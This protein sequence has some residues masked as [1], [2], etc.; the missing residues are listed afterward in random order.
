ML[1]TILDFYD[2]KG[3]FSKTFEWISELLLNVYKVAVKSN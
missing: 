3:L 2:V 1:P